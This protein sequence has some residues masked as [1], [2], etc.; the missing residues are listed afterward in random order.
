MQKRVKEGKSKLII[1]FL[2]LIFSILII[3]FVSA[4]WIDWLKSIT[5]RASSEPTNISISITGPNAV[6][7]TVWNNSLGSGV[8]PIA[9]SYATLQF[10]VTVTDADGYSDVNTSSVSANI[11]YNSVET[12]WS[13]NSTGCGL[14][15]GQDTSTSRNFSCTILI[16]FYAL[17]AAWRINVTATDLGNKT[18]RTNDSTNFTINQLKS[19]QLSPAALT[20]P[21]ISL[22]ATNQT[23]NN[24]PT[25][26]NNTGNY[27]ASGK[28]NITAIDLHGETTYSE[29]LG[30]RNFT[31]D[32]ATGGAC[33]GAACTECD[34]TW[35]KNLTAATDKTTVTI[36]VL[37][38]GNVTLNDGTA[39]EDL[40]WCIVQVPSSISSQTYST[41]TSG[42]W[43]IEVT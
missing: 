1:M 15:S 13:T 37:E 39:R 16:P 35:L 28:V 20:W 12:A 4:S 6:N 23:S 42:S 34:G 38:R 31:I 11:S 43:T 36:A 32:I 5:G 40:Y 3:T 10:N 17:N 7:I 33:S 21:S 9:G 8:T 27:N 29:I 30:A 24:D 2:F 41:N 26:I 18:Q 14:T 25:T 19:I 22:G